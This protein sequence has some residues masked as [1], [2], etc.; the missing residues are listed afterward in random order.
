VASRSE[1]SRRPRGGQHA[2]RHGKPSRWRGG[3]TKPA[4][5]PPVA[6]QSP[7]AAGPDLA[8]FA[9]D[10]ALDHDDFFARDDNGD[11]TAQWLTGPTSATQR[12][13]WEI[14]DES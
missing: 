1:A 13:P 11:G 7:A 3:G 10:R 6:P 12:P 5:S 9:P 14:G 2:A 4:A 8:E